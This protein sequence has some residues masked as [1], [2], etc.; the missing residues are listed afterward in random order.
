MPYAMLDN[1]SILAITERLT[2]LSN[3]IQDVRIH[4]RTENGN[5]H[6]KNNMPITVTVLI[7]YNMPNTETV[8]G[9]FFRTTMVLGI[10]F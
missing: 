1:S 10:K 3:L 8:L 2:V 4:P 7:R 6:K 9:I 5:R